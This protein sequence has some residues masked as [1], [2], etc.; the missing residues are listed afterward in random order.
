MAQFVRASNPVFGTQLIPTAWLQTYPGVWT[1][2]DEDDVGPNPDPLPAYVRDVDLAAQMATV[3]GN[4]ASAFSVAQR[5]AFGAR[6]SVKSHGA[7]GDGTTDDRA[8]IQA[9]INAASAGDTVFFPKGVYVIGTASNLGLTLK[10][11]IR[12]LG[13][14]ATIKLKTGVGNWTAILRANSASGVTIEQL[15]IDCNYAGNPIVDASTIATTTPRYVVEANNS[16]D[17][18]L[19]QVT[20]TGHSGRNT[21]Y[22]SGAGQKRF[23]VDSCRFLDMGNAPADQGFDHSTIYAEAV[24]VRVI[25]N[26]FVGA[27]PLGAHAAIETHAPSAVVTGNTVEGY[28]MLGNI[29]GVQSTDGDNVVVTGNIGRRL[30]AGFALYSSD[31]NLGPAPGLRNLV[32]SHNQITLDRDLHLPFANETFI[33]MPVG[34]YMFQ[35]GDL[36]VENIDISNNQFHFLD[37]SAPANVDESE[38]C[39]ISW[40]RTATPPSVD[41]RVRIENNTIVNCPGP[42]IRYSSVPGID[43]LRI[44][45]NTIVNPGGSNSAMASTW[46]CGV[47]VTGSAGTFR[48]IEIADNLIIDDRGTHLIA[49]GVDVSTIGAVTNGRATGNV[50]RC[51][52]GTSLA[53]FAPA[54]GTG[55]AFYVEHEQATWLGLFQPVKPGSKVYVRSTGATYVNTQAVDGSAP[56]FVQQGYG[57]VIAGTTPTAA[58]TPGTVTARLPVYSADGGTVLGYLPIYNTIT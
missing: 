47:I 48:D 21:F 40:R 30:M 37:W 4:P 53:G 27:S 45:G 31:T 19:R 52:D 8:A 57:R 17:V 7:T 3:A 34:V 23:T 28:G 35:T 58:T 39:G 13:Q 43:Q 18:T 6:V 24:D 5:A 36:P 56:T 41:K 14:D 2:L 50:V 15:T 12:L 44:R 10:P 25:D 38:A 26:V 1:P 46:R 42:G 51:A 29:T 33:R 20:V 22:C 32:L 16:N 11:G 55:K 9:A 49:G 54:T